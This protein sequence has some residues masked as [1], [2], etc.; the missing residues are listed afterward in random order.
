MGLDCLTRNLE[1][2]RL[3]ESNEV[4][5]KPGCSSEAVE[6]YISFLNEKWQR[7]ARL[8]IE[9]NSGNEKFQGIMG[10]EHIKLDHL[11]TKNCVVSRSRSFVVYKEGPERHAKGK[12]EKINVLLS[13][14]LP[15][16]SINLIIKPNGKKLVDPDNDKA[17]A[18]VEYLYEQMQVC[19]R[20]T[21]QL[22]NKKN[23]QFLYVRKFEKVTCLLL[24]AGYREHDGMPH[25]RLME[26]ELGSL[27]ARNFDSMHEP[28]IRNYF[29]MINWSCLNRRPVYV[30]DNCCQRLQQTNDG[31]YQT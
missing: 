23:I 12:K 5:V 29:P 26:R 6:E 3:E 15:E 28:E 30:V 4:K 14:F 17:D 11:Y 8:L 1:K 18:V 22:L 13:S 10:T 19:W 2:V 7:F 24:I 25:F 31:I 27:E 9:T 20:V 16:M 21:S